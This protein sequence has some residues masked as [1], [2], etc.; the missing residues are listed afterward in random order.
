[1]SKLR[2][3]AVLVFALCFTIP[4]WPADAHFPTN[5]DLRQFRA[6]SDPRVSP[7]GKHVLVRVFDDTA[8]GGRPHLWLVDV[9]SNSYRQ[10]TYSPANLAKDSKYRGEDSGEWM[11][12]GQSIL[13]LAHRGEQN[14]IF[15]LPLHGGEASAFD[16]KVAPQV[17][18]STQPG[19]L[20]P[21]D[22]KKQEP[23]KSLPIDVSGFQIAPNGTAI[24]LWAKDPQTPGEKHQK[25]EKVDALWVD[26]E[27]HGT[28]LYLLD[29]DSSKLTPV[30]VPPNVKAVSWGPNSDRLMAEVDAP[31]HAGDLGPAGSTWLVLAD[32]PQ[33]PSKLD[34]PPTAHSFAWT[35]DGKVA[36]YLAQAAADA[37]PGYQD[38]YEFSFDTKAS[39]DLSGGLTGSLGHEGPITESGGSAV[40]LVENGVQS[41]FARFGTKLSSPQPLPFPGPVVHELNTNVARSAWVYLSTSSTQP[42]SLY[43]TS[44]ISNPGRPLALPSLT[45][46]GVQNAES[47]LITWK[48]E[49]KTIEGLLYLPPDAKSHKVPLVV[50]VHGGPTGA[51]QDTYDQLISFFV[52]QGWMILRPNPRGSTGHGAEFAA[53]NKNDLGGG[54][55]RDIMAGVDTVLKE[56]PADPD[57]LALVGYSYG[58]EMAGF[59]EGKTTIF[60]AIV[61]GA[62]VINQFSE[63]GTEDGSWYDR[64]FYG[65]P[66]DHFADAWRQSPISF[67]PNARSP[68]LLLQ[69]QDDS[70]DPPGQSREMY[71]ALRQYGVP[72]DLV[73]YP[74]VNHG[75]LAQAIYGQPSAEPWH[76]FD[77]RRRIVEFIGKAFGRKN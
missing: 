16:L 55:Y 23:A 53:A 5:E 34:L 37:P 19:A 26:H 18:D 59:V 66:W 60:K 47:Q 11:A 24:A 72:V 62:P 31:N 38:L 76:G 74:R 48:S 69:G 4:A 46:T 49:G 54:D 8:S 14:Q 20:P 12:D 36:F 73:E 57:R 63:Y 32:D 52:G 39:K 9:Q 43:I 45:P 64:W 6:V 15:R 50:D 56:F 22:D 42:N 2:S 51:W 27:S 35:T 67:V 58:G 65:K 25:D 75:P 17:D 3:S 21:S 13:F 7:D 1:M 40:T 70:V 44:T 28:R 10:V 30:T 68:F 61:C 71:R 41:G 33:H 29:P 77:A